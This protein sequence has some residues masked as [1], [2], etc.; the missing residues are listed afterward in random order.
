MKLHTVK[1]AQEPL[2][3]V[4]SGSRARRTC[5]L[6]GHSTKLAKYAGKVAGQRNE[7][8]IPHR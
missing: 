6:H 4:A 5:A 2:Q 3:I 8:D 7:Q 1:Q